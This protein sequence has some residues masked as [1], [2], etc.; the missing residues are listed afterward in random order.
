MRYR[1]E[2]DQAL[3]LAQDP[4]TRGKAEKDYCRGRAFAYNVVARWLEGVLKRMKT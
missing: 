2:Q 3:M 4:E 1:R